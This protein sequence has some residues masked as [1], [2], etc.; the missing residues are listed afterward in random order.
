MELAQRLGCFS[1]RRV[2]LPE[3]LSD[4]RGELVSCFFPSDHRSCQPE[5]EG[6]LIPPCLS[7][8]FLQSHLPL[9]KMRNPTCDPFLQDP[10]P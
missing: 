7:L 9:P 3:V 4:F 2:A 10:P 5:E 6:R 1:E 8:L